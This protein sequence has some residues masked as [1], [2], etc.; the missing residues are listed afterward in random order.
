MTVELPDPEGYRWEGESLT[1]GISDPPATGWPRVSVITPSFNQGHYLDAT[2]RSVLLQRYPN[3]EY[4]VMDGGSSDQSSRIIRK[5]SDWISHWRSHKDRGQSAAINEGLSHATGEIVAYLNS[6]D[7]YVP[8]AI[9]NAVRAMEE[10]NRDWVAGGCTFVDDRGN[11]QHTWLPRPPPADRALA[12]VSPWGVPQPSCFWRRDLFTRY[13]TFREDMS[14]TFD[15]DFQV[16]LALRGCNPAILSDVLSYATLHATSKTQTS[17]PRFRIED[18]RFL[19][20]YWEQLTRKER[21]HACLRRA[22]Q[23]AT[24]GN[25]TAAWRHV[26]RAVRAS[27]SGALASAAMM[28]YGRTRR[29]LRS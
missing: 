16:R 26:A 6:D 15:T 13:G 9:A 12:V 4:I 7:R 23:F 29:T 8:G 5:Y 20:L 27:P 21:A 2:I 24:E 11:H 19:E 1:A 18:K 10:Q 28:A 17:L 25:L 3:L 14:Y 22:T